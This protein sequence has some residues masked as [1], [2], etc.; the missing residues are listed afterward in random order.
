MHQ[1]ELR[2]VLLIQAIEETDRAG[3]V[4]PLADRADASRAV[5]RESSKLSEAQPSASL[6]A[7]SQA[8]LVKRSARLLDPLR[9]RSPVVMHVLALAGGLTWLGRFVLV[10]ALAAGV[11]LSAL[12]GSRRINILAF[13]L[14]GLIAWNLL[15]Y[16]LLLVTWLRSR[17]RPATGFWSAAMYERWIAGRIESLM[18]HSTRY[19]VPLSAGLRRFAAEW[20]ALSRP[21]LFLRAKRLLHLAAALLAI[22]LVIG[23]YV[24]G[25]V[26]R[27]EA[28]WES[29]F[30]GPQSAYALVS[31]LYGPASALSG[32]SFGSAGDIA[33]LR[34]TATGGGGDAAPW[35]HLI[36]ITAALYIAVP[37]LCA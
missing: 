24:R 32:I 29:T 14:I 8:F 30:L 11:S 3:E 22:G 4:I 36:A 25:I 35:I 13:P 26:L 5:I 21:I 19:N 31:V 7:R 12:D 20:G 37:R 28:G 1:R 2:T 27:Y 23:L 16:V 15:V 18:R 9:L 10:V 6:S 34:W 33:A 17:G